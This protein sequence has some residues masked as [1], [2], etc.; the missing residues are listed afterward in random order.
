MTTTT[1]FPYCLLSPSV[2]SE[3]L[4]RLLA[5]TTSHLA[6]RAPAHVSSEVI[7]CFSAHKKQRQGEYDHRLPPGERGTPKQ[8]PPSRVC[9]RPAALPSETA[10]SRTRQNAALH[11]SKVCATSAQFAH[12]QPHLML[13]C[14]QRIAVLCASLLS[15]EIQGNAHSHLS[16]ALPCHKLF[17]SAANLCFY[18][19]KAK[20]SLS[21]LSTEN[22]AE[23]THGRSNLPIRRA[24]TLRSQLV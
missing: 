17:A 11:D 12:E 21:R 3:V 10:A 18:I 13:F 16:P 7:S 20:G 9:L 15:A 19:L 1:N 2:L 22:R 14:S 24:H 5:T 23:L 8:H 6:Y 4:R